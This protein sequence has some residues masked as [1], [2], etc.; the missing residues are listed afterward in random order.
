MPCCLVSS[1]AMLSFCASVYAEVEESRISKSE[2]ICQVHDFG[3]ASSLPL[4]AKLQF[5]LK[6]TSMDLLGWKS[7]QPD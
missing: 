6:S 2:S 1:A 7:N 4:Q 5:A 3:T